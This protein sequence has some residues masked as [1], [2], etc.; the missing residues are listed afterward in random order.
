M[1]QKSGFI[2]KFQDELVVG[3]GK[4][5]QFETLGSQDAHS[6]VSPGSPTP[7][8]NAARRRFSDFGRWRLSPRRFS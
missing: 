4:L 1:A 8:D 5:A 6:A 2:Q 3:N 7:H